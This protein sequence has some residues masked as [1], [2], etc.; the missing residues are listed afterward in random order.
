MVLTIAAAA[1][2]GI[3]FKGDVKNPPAAA[4]TSRRRERNGNSWLSQTPGRV[5]PHWGVRLNAALFAGGW[6]PM[7][8]RFGA[9]ASG[10]CA[11]G[12][13]P[14]L[15]GPGQAGGTVDATGGSPMGTGTPAIATARAPGGLHN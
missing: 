7:R 9:W 13:A 15:Q 11:R 2:P 8:A 14:G 1:S 10:P 5:A 12:E 4:P 3:P 6:L